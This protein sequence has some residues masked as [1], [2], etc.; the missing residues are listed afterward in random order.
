LDGENLFDLL[1]LIKEKH[2]DRKEFLK[3]LER[4]ILAVNDEYV[5]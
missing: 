1:K 4:S 2:G 5:F 3:V